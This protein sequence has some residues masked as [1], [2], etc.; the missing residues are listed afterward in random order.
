MITYSILQKELTKLFTQ[1]GIV[2]AAVDS[3]LL[4][5]ELAGISRP[6]IFL[7]ANELIPVELEQQIRELARRRAN[8]EPLQ[9][10][11][12]V[13]YFRDLKLEVTPAVLIPRPET[14]LLV[15]Y[16]IKYLPVGGSML[17]LGTGSGAIALSMATERPDAQITAVDISLEAL[18]VAR[19]NAITYQCK[20]RF[21]HSNLFAE[22]EGERFD[23]IGANLPY[24]SPEEYT[25][26]EPEVRLF[27]PA[28]ALTA[29]DNGF[30]LIE[31]AAEGLV[32]HLNPGGRAIFEL[33]PALAPRLTEALDKTGAFDLVEVLKDYNQRDRFVS[34]R[35]SGKENH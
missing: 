22:L 29:A 13:A 10:L 15:D 34:V 6:E 21:L 28:L 3:E 5:T 26:L 2:S 20:V 4:I 12:K 24:V 9:Y 25:Q 1:A 16:A 23:L 32:D 35:Y 31:R 8:R 18:E 14:E 19:R 17:D 27:E 7:Y 11:L 30:Q 33:S